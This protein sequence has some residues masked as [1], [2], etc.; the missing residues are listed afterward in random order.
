MTS[1]FIK[2]IIEDSCQDYDIIVLKGFSPILI[3]ELG[4][5]LL[6][7]D[8]YIFE[9]GKIVLDRINANSLMLSI[10]NCNSHQ[11]AICT[12]ESLIMM[13]TQIANLNILNKR[14]CVIDNNFFELYPNPTT[15][16]IP[17]FDS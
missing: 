2:Q 5:H 7:L 1:L 14:I 13:C 16:D 6:L 9:N 17:D 8:N 12:C 11:K 10:L 15:S 4:E 3:T